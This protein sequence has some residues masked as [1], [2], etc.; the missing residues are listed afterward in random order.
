MQAGV[1]EDL[2]PLASKFMAE[3]A[4]REQILAEAAAAASASS[5]AQ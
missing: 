1:V 2:N 4:N 5:D 3:E